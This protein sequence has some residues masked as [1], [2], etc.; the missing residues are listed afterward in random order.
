MAYLTWPARH[1][2][3]IAALYLVLIPLAIIAI[4]VLGAVEHYQSRSETRHAVVLLAR[5][6]CSAATV[7]E[8]A[9][10]SQVTKPADRTAI[11][12]FFSHYTAPINEA[13]VSLGADPCK[14]VTP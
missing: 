13:L 6:D 12:R 2:R 3:V 1:D 7:F 11:I 4:A 14:E 10:L 9:A 5:A 8:Q